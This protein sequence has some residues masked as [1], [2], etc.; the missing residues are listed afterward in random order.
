MT[1]LFYSKL[2]LTCLALTCVK[3]VPMAYIR[4]I[5]NNFLVFKYLSQSMC[6][7]SF[8]NVSGE[9]NLLLE[10]ATLIVSDA[11]ENLDYKSFFASGL[12]AV[13]YSL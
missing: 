6:F 13:K 3:Y 5:G 10:K 1:H 8:C 2:S 12:S 7:K 4:I 9:W 11:S